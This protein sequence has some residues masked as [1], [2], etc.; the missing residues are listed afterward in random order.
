MKSPVGVQG[1]KSPLGFGAKPQK[2]RS[3]DEIPSG[4]AGGKAPAGVVG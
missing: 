2:K 4:G 1:T 3:G